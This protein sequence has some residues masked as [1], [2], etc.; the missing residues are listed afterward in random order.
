MVL[1]ANTDTRAVY[2]GGKR[3]LGHEV[4]QFQPEW[5]SL[6]GEHCMPNNCINALL[7]AEVGLGLRQ[8]AVRGATLQSDPGDPGHLHPGE[9]D[10]GGHGM[11]SGRR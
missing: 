7:S 10:T 11:L 4:L 5:F 3:A 2:T 1:D 6:V 9:R 8:L